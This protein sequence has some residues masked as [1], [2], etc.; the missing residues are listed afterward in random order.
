MPLIAWSIKSALNTPSIDRVLV[1]T[2]CPDIQNIAT[3][4]GADAPFLR[5]EV[6]AHDS[7]TSSDAAL[8]ALDFA[9]KHWG[10][11]DGVILLEPTSPLRKKDDLEKGIHLF[12]EKYE[13]ID[14]VVSLGQV[15]LENPVHMKRVVQ[16]LIEPIEIKRNDDQ[17]DKYYF[18]YGVMYLI[19]TSVLRE[20]HTFYADRMLPFFIERW[21][22]YEVDDEYDFCCVES[23]LKMKKNEVML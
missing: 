4:F 9:E 19:K 17:E 6:L 18:P 7:A 23:I 22:N 1:S 13:E 12:K 3:Q 10:H 15:G 5:P 11:Y 8:H 20:K 21:Q 2:D 16:G 14:G